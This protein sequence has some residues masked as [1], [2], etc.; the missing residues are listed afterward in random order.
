MKTQMRFQKILSI[1]SLVIA[2]LTFVY[3][4]Y[5]LTGSMGEVP[6]YFNRQGT[7]GD[8]INAD[9]FMSTSQDFVSTLVA[10]GITFIVLAVLIFLTSSHNRRKYYATN[11]IAMGLFVAFALA[12]SLYAF[13][14]IA[15]VQDLFLNDICW[16]TGTGVGGDHNVADQWIID[17][18]LYR[19]ETNF[20][21]GYILFTVVIVNAIVCA[22]STVWKILLIRGEKKLLADSAPAEVTAEEV[23]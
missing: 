19:T 14:M 21:L 11:Y 12:I 16:K 6:Y 17:H 9:K 13:I 22:L 4:L 10:L 23:A 18:K 2:A 15:K 8:L 3:A 20:I 7:Q 5:F 1:V